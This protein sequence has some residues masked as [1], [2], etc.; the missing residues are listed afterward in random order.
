MSSSPSERVV[1]GMTTP[2]RMPKYLIK[3]KVN[4]PCKYVVSKTIDIV[5]HNKVVLLP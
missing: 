1:G 4:P 3:Y 2:V 5:V